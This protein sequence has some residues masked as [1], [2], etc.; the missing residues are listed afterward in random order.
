MSSATDAYRQRFGLGREAVGKSKDGGVVWDQ[1]LAKRSGQKHVL[2][3]GVGICTSGLV[4]A[5]LAEG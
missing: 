4:I 3:C 5:S 1:D 2:G